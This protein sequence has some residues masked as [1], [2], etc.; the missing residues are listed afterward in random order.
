MSVGLAHLYPCKL[1]LI[2]GSS[3]IYSG[4][5][6]LDGFCQVVGV[7]SALERFVS[8]FVNESRLSRVHH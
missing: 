8:R 6:S 3:T 7:L 2:A 4:L 1:L 5:D